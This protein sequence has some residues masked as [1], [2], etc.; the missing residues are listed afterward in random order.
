MALPFFFHLA[1]E[2]SSVLIWVVVNFAMEEICHQSAGCH[3]K[4]RV[5]LEVAIRSGS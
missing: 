1:V 5:R 2:A 4:N 3:G